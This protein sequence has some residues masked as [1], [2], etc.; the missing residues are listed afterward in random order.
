[1]PA[2][3]MAVEFISTLFATCPWDRASPRRFE[4]GSSVFSSSAMMRGP[5][6]HE[7]DERIHVFLKLQHHTFKKI[8][9]RWKADDKQHKAQTYLERK[10]DD[11]D[12][13]LGHG[14]GNDAQ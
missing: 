4:V 8:D 2:I 12:I 7:L 6:C 14:P 9:E 10:T 11:K 1:M 3:K 5:L 13:H